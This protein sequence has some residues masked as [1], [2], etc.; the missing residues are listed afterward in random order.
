MSFSYFLEEK[1]K[2]SPELAWERSRISLFYV[3]PG[4]DRIRIFKRFRHVF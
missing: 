1:E 4:Y 3:K 2:S